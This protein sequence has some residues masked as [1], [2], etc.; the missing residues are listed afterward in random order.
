MI[1]LINFLIFNIYIAQGGDYRL[2]FTHFTG[3]KIKFHFFSHEFKI[4]QKSPFY[5]IKN[6]LYF[7]KVFI[8]FIFSNILIDFLI[9]YFHY[10]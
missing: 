8:Q 3:F 7:F 5:F 6:Y 1:G 10:D 9:S 2:W 4:P